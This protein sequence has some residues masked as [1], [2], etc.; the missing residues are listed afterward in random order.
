MSR[1]PTPGSDNGV[2]GDIL[3]DFLG[4]EHEA[5]G[6]LKIRSDG[7]LGGYYTK[8]AGGIP[9]PDLTTDVQVSLARADSAVQAVTVML[10]AFSR[11]GTLA[12]TTGTVGL[13]V[14]GTYQITGV[15]ARVATPP[16]GAALVLD[17]R[18][19][20]ASV[21]TTAANR[22]TIPDSSASTGPGTAPDDP[23]LVE[24]DVLTV[25]IVRVG[26]AVAGADLVVTISARRLA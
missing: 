19:N 26:S 23:G 13:P 18:K 16:S 17:V 5:D 12:V 7:T 15:F 10:S 1:L 2:W 14:D 25:D 20:G 9:R 21:F 4:V 11:T 8:P 22:P 3:N 24:G 6:R